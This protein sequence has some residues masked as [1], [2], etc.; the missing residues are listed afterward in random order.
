VDTP[1][2]PACTA[3]RLTIVQ[4]GELKCSY[5]GSS[6]RGIPLVCP[7]CGWINNIEA[8]D[9]PECGEPLSVF[10]QVIRRRD[11][12][13][14]PQW[15]KRV[16]SQLEEMRSDEDRASQI[17]LQA[18]KEIDQTREK[19]ISDQKEAQAKA[20]RTLYTLVAI[21]GILVILSVI[22]LWVVFR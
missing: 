9:C 12:T 14:E 15:K 16:Q 13:G 22:M 21:I 3:P 2:C 11:T 10:A 1:A 8:E 4:K 18:L 17:R 5:C 20:D 19:A 7:S 6:F